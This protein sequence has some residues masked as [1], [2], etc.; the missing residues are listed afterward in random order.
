MPNYFAMRDDRKFTAADFEAGH[1]FDGLRFQV[2]AFTGEKYFAFTQGTFDGFTAIVLETGLG[3]LITSH[4]IFE[5]SGR[6]DD[7][8][9]RF[10]VASVP[11]NQELSSHYIELR[12]GN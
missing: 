4:F 2:P 12:R 7:V 9:K 8:F 10:W 5:S 6:I 11:Y 1:R 3:Q